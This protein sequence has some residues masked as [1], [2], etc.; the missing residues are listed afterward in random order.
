VPTGFVIDQAAVVA[1]PPKLAP[2]N[3]IALGVADEQILIAGPGVTVAEGVTFIILVSVSGWQ[4][5]PPS[6]SFEVRVNVTVPV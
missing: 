1:L 4:G 6:G 2:V 5:P 3:G